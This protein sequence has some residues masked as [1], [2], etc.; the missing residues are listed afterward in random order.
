MSLVWQ[1]ALPVASV[2]LVLFAGFSSIVYWYSK[3]AL[4]GQSE[5]ALVREAELIKANLG[6][7]DRTLRI[8]AER[9]GKAFFSMFDGAPLVLDTEHTVF[10]GEFDSPLL[11]HKGQPI[12]LDFAYV[13]RFTDFTGGTATVFVR[14]R[15]DFLRISTSLKKQDGSRAI[16][17]LLGTQH[18]GYAALLRG[19]KYVGRAHLFGRDYM[20]EYIPVQDPAG[21]VIAVLYIG[22]DF[23][24]GLQALYESVA[25][26]RF[27]ASGGASI[28]GARGSEVGRAIVH[29]ELA[30]EDLRDWR[31]PSDEPI[32]AQMLEQREGVM[33]YPWRAES[34]GKERAK[35][36]AFQSFDPWGLLI[37]TEGYED[38]LAA[39]SLSLGNWVAVLGLVV[40][41]LLIGLTYVS[42]RHGLAPLQGIQQALRRIS[43]GD[44]TQ[45]ATVAEPAEASHNEIDRLAHDLNSVVD[46]IQQLIMRIIDSAAR[47]AEATG[48][49]GA[50]AES[51]SGGVQRQHADTDALAS[52]I[53]E[54]S[55]SGQE[56][57]GYAQTA[58]NETRSVDDLVQE[59]QRVVTDSMSSTEALA[60][61]IEDSARMLDKVDTDTQ[62]IG[63]VLEVIRDIAEQTNLL[64]LNAAIEAARAGEQGRGFAV[65]ADEVRSLAQ[66]SQQSTQEIRV[67]IE[68]LQSGTRQAVTTMHSGLERSHE[69]VNEARRASSALDAIAASMGKLSDMTTEI[70]AAMEQQRSVS[71]EVNRNI[72]GIR[73]VANDTAAQSN[74]LTAAVQALE[75]L[76]AGL[77]SDV[78]KFK[79]AS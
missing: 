52:A 42:L 32:F 45:R 62:A 36:A 78:A 29:L 3:Q 16:G 30:G 25:E 41:A 77:Q 37:V 39:A 40:I 9:L 20:T 60:A 44:I 22:F 67:I 35:L 33:S 74:Q 4:L 72:V 66:R 6:F 55:A 58:A 49:L 59:G 27:G 54:L 73:D 63:T 28:I 56:V 10:V 19:E 5:Q 61:A 11:T 53:T 26:L 79:V 71:E 69:S 7:Y 64:A 46:N 2:A 17:T 38:E 68:S 76:A 43:E 47:V 21:Q 13:D 65:V 31:G 70:A 12:N 18:P 14:Y 1:T 15:D 57:A 50:V 48:T 51:N 23:T 34:T 8:N 24:A 75:D